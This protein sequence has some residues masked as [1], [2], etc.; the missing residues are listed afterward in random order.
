MLSEIG[1][2]FWIYILQGLFIEYLLLQMLGAF[3]M[4]HHAIFHGLKRRIMLIVY[5]MHVSSRANGS[6]SI[7]YH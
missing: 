5:Q 3:Q 4:A 6:S 2:D 7:Y 1:K